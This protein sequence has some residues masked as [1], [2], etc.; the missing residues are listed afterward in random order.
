MPFAAVHPKD[1]R[2]HWA[3]IRVGLLEVLD[4]SPDSWIPEDVYVS[5]RAGESALFIGAEGETLTSFMVVIK[6][7]IEFTN[8]PVLHIWIAHSSGE[9]GITDEMVG[10]LKPIAE[11]AGC[12]Q[13]T[14]TSS[15]VGW[16]KRHNLMKACY[17]I[18]VA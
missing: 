10:F 15:R 12:K 5:I 11:Q 14:F 16:A 4:R 1:L 17:S 7:E 2:K 6:Q 9:H 18:E 3:W 13:I 8:E